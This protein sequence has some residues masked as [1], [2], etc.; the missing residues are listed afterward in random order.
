M[1]LT[2][3]VRSRPRAL[4]AA[5]RRYLSSGIPY[6]SLSIG[7]PK[8]TAPREK[9]VAHTPESVAK[10]T[11]EGFP[12]IVEA[13][14]GA[15]ADFS[16]EA[17]KAAGATLASREQAFGAGLVAKVMPPT[18]EEAKL[19]GDRMLLSFV[20]PAQN[21]ALIKQLQEQKAT[22]FAMDCIPRTLSR[23]QAFDALSSQANIAGYRAV[24][25]ASSVFGRFFAGQM[26]AAG[27]VAPAKV[28]VLG[29]GVAGLAAVQTAKNMGAIVRLFDVRAAVKEQAQSLGAEFLEV[30]Y[31]ESGEGSGGYAKEMSKEWHAEAQKML[32][33]QCEEVD[34]IITTALIPG[35]K[36][37][38]MV[39]DEM[40]KKMKPGSVTV[41]LAASA[42][43][44]VATT[45]ADEMIVTPNG[46]KCI[47]YTDLNSRLASTSSTL[48]ANNQQKW[49]LA[50]GPTTTKEKGVFKL[51]PEDIAVRGMTVL[52]KGELKWPWTPPPPPPPPPKPEPK[53]EVVLTDD[54]YKAMY[55][56]D[57]KRAGY[58]AAV[59]L[60]VGIVSPT[61]AF[62]NM[63][64]TFA[65][66]GVIGYQVVWGVA[67]SLHSP[68]MAVT[69]A[70]SG[71]TAVGG[72]Y[73]MGG[74]LMP[75]TLAETLGFTATAISA[76]NITG[77]FLVTK[78]M[79]DMFKRPTDPPEYYEYYAYPMAG[80]LG[81]FSLISLGFPEAANI[82]ATASALGCI[83]G[84]AGLASQ[85]T[86]RLG[87][88]SGMAGVSTGIAATIA[89]LDWPAATYVQL[90]A[91]LGGGGAAGYVI[92]KRVDPTSLPQTVA[93]FH[94]LV[95][96]AAVFSAGADYLAHAAHSP[97]LLDTVRLTSIALASVIGGVTTTGSVIAFGKLN[98]NLTSAPLQLAQRDYI[99]MGMG[100]G[101][102]AC[103][104][105][106]IA[107]PSPAA[108]MLALAG[109]GVLSGGLGLHMTASIGGAD[110][111][112]VITVLNSY[113]GWALCAEGFMLDK[114]LLTTVGALIG[115]SGAILTHIMCVAMNRDIVSVL[116]GG[117]GTSATGKGEAMVFEGE[118][119]FTDVDQAVDALKT[120]KEVIVVPGYGLAVANG[121]Y[122]MAEIAKT[123]RNQGVNLRFAIHPVAGR[124]PGQL[125]VLLAEAGV[126]YDIV[127]EM[128]E[129][130]DDFKSADLCLVVGAND[131]VNSA[132]IEDPNSIIAGMPVLH[133]WE[134]KNVI[135]M[136]RSMG[137]GYAGADNPVFFKENTDMLLGD[138][139]KTLDAIKA[140]LEE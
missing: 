114:P 84:I 1:L 34:I 115:S 68:L 18:A 109:M 73:T 55:M 53:P 80:F 88:V 99:N 121:Q 36:A 119:T 7:V 79:L 72:M 14:A 105:L 51:D 12:V 11:K 67:H 95:G 112:V 81:G 49:I 32:A 101:T 2:G 106:M 30:D 91:A 39:T 131:T 44:N 63:F 61:A 77:G 45:V 3:R 102:L 9:R 70:V 21:E 103:M 122:A 52:E 111:P 82:A 66:S 20:Y 15:A 139:K 37:P 123:L 97:E 83:G 5:A 19:I 29:G 110:M 50:A 13:G 62:S 27:K 65:L 86:A 117:Y 6:A 16:D 108:G 58:G 135:V 137:A 47:G 60:G 134:A 26:T 56:A 92:A 4:V 17:Y 96:L 33:K 10:L 76:I 8:E 132:A 140:K 124:M 116:L 89:S 136:K 107:N 138:A 42:G 75:S 64:T 38:V 93:A 74:G 85:S 118:A 104:G 130:N 48:Y 46:V 128:E 35:K 129:I 133:V 69:N 87:L 54:D 24:I 43:G 113:S 28:L 71:M 126:P 127:L 94:S 59:M 41:D 25:E 78:K 40:V 98:G 100:A 31:E 23:G 90:A 120:A 22:V 125:N 57:A